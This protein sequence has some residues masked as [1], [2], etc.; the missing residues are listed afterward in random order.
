MIILPRK[1]KLIYARTLLTSKYS[2]LIC[3]STGVQQQSFESI[4]I[5][6]HTS[7]GKA[8]MTF[9]RLTNN[10]LFGVCGPTVAGETHC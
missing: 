7:F 1:I 5:C 3:F 9:I 4:L 6:C 2:A 8:T 10:G